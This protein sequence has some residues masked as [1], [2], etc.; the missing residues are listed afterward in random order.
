MFCKQVTEVLNDD[1]TAFA[2]NL[3][4]C[5]ML[6]LEQHY[7]CDIA[8]QYTTSYATK[9]GKATVEWLEVLHQIQDNLFEEDA[10]G[11][12][13]KDVVG[14]Y[15]YQLTCS[16]QRPKEECVFVLSGGKISY[17]SESTKGCSVNRVLLSDITDDDTDA[18]PSM[19][20][21]FDALMKRYQCRKQDNLHL[22]LYKW[23]VCFASKSRI[24]P[25]FYG[26]A[27][28]PSNPLDETWSKNVLII[29]KPWHGKPATVKIGFPTYVDA[30]LAFLSDPEFPRTVEA[31]IRKTVMKVNFDPKD[32]NQYRDG[33]PALTPPE[34]ASG[35]ASKIAD[36]AIGIA[37]A[38]GAPS[39]K[40]LDTVQDARFSTEELAS[41]DEGLDLDWS[42]GFKLSGITYLAEHRKEFYSD[43]Q[44]SAYIEPF[45][46]FDSD[47]YAPENCQGFAQSFLVGIALHALFLYYTNPALFDDPAHPCWNV[48][49]QGNPGTGKTFIIKTVLNAIRLVS[50]TMAAAQP[51]A[52]T[53]CAASLANGKTLNRFFHFPFGKKVQQPP[54][55]FTNKS[56]SSVESYLR[57][58]QSLFGYLSDEWSMKSRSSFAWE[59]HRLSKGRRDLVANADRK[60]GGVPL[61]FQFG[62]VQQLPAV[63]AKSLHD[64][65]APKTPQSSDAVG[66]LMFNDFLNARHPSDHSIPIVMDKVIRQKDPAF[67]AV[68]QKMRDGMM[69]DVAVDFLLRRRFELLSPE[70][71]ELFLKEAI[72]LMPTWAR[73]KPINIRYLQNLGNPIVIV[74]ADTSLV[75]HPSHL[76][77][78]SVPVTSFWQIVLWRSMFSMGKLVFAKPLFFQNQ[79]DQMIMIHP[80]ALATLSSRCL[81]IS[82]WIRCGIRRILLMSPSQTTISLAHM[83]AVGLRQFPFES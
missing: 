2:E 11:H 45:L 60:F 34:D 28:R 50:G 36:E 48:M 59:E 82:L 54:F 75:K 29:F 53:G 62:D 72:F 12:T 30:L 20:F 49:V 67:K 14:K 22:N 58:M 46:L 77:D 7:G 15:M 24:V 39:I 21:S 56:T 74:H 32:G 33:A 83:V 61:R 71:Q 42:D 43:R 78:F 35:V 8:I 64:P 68:L 23:S 63:A 51:T 5:G 79:L 41:F 17:N 10:H 47:V 37:D 55:D 76:S 66:R 3:N 44:A 16:K 38:M 65:V 1:Y 27:D 69:D 80:A 57:D 13:F 18:A 9:G 73:T 19:G 70:E 31:A 81:T 40:F 26:Y 25:N 52:P 6:G 4:L